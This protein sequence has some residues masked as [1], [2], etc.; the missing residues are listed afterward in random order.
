MYS[1]L[2]AA[3]FISVAVLAVSLPAL[4]VAEGARAVA[5]WVRPLQ[6]RAVLS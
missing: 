3:F 2:I 4:V 5:A 1:I 6:G